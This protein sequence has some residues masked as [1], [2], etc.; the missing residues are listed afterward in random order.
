[1]SKSSGK[2][3][4]PKKFLEAR[5]PPKV[6]LFSYQNISFYQEHLHYAREGRTIDGISWSGD[7]YW[8]MNFFPI[9]LLKKDKYGNITDEEVLA[10]PYPSQADDYLFKQFAEAKAE[11]QHVFFITARGYGKTFAVISKAAKN[12]YTNPLSHNYISASISKHADVTFKKLK[13][14]MEA[15]EKLHPTLRMKKLYDSPDYVESGEDIITSEGNKERVGHRSKL[16]KIVYDSDAGKTR[17]SRP[18]F[19]LFE[20]VGAWTGAASLKKCYGESLGSFKR[21]SRMTCEVFFIGTGGQ[22]ESGGSEDARDMFYN[23]DAYNLY[24]VREWSDRPTAI[25]IPAEAKYGGFYEHIYEPDVKGARAALETERLLKKDSPDVYYQ[26][27][28]EYPFKPEE[29]FLVRGGNNFNTEILALQKMGITEEKK[30]QGK[31]CKLHWVR[32][33][34]KIV[35]VEIEYTDKGDIWLLEEPE[36]DENGKVYKNLYVGGYDG[37][38]LGTQDTA[39]GEGSQG[40]ICIKKRML[41]GLRTN[42]RYVCFYKDR[43]K[44]IDSFYDNALK[45]VTLFDCTINIEDTKRAIVAYFKQRKAFDRFM[46]RPRITL[47]TDPTEE[48]KTNLI[49][50]TA[51]PK[52]FGYGE[53]YLAQYIKDFGHDIWYLEALNQLIDF[54]M[55]NRT[56][57]D[58]VI[59]MMMCEIGDDE[60]FDTQVRS[61][62]QES[63]DYHKY[64][65]Y[66]DVNG[67][68]Q[69]GLLPEFQANPF[70]NT[71]FAHNRAHMKSNVLYLDEDYNS[72]VL[73]L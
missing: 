10:F 59:S 15:L 70:A 58:V 33:E 27:I 21:G 69:W 73:T 64:G 45:I 66:T 14:S 7:Y 72:H 4:L 39:T 28:Q 32:E 55:Q 8:F 12:Y 44:D 40:A 6:D 51:T 24:K 38:D 71:I 65:Y 57:F 30:K 50:T 41:S 35:G 17:G 54:N 5:T 67:K 52:N 47:T 20:E 62:K 25:F 42:N 34:G 23:P 37:I 26:F 36:K 29:A 18:R 61:T 13:E 3:I 63:F 1:M 16:E 43:P 49:G 53:L 2:L 31:L 56:K 60:L 68:R 48:Q 22:M 9:N 46:K 11:G 19:Q